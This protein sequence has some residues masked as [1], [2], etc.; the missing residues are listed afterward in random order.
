VGGGIGGGMHP[1][2][3]ER[4]AQRELNINHD[5]IKKYALLNMPYEGYI[6][7]YERLKD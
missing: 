3:S 1:S 4:D 2:L 7:S 6:F 5:I